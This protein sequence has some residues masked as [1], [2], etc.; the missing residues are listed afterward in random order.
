MHSMACA[1]GR[2]EHAESQAMGLC[3]HQN[4]LK[5]HHNTYTFKSAFQ[6]LPDVQIQFRDKFSLSTF[7]GDFKFH[8]FKAIQGYFSY[9]FLSVL[10]V[11]TYTYLPNTTL[12][13]IQ[14]ARVDMTLK[15][16]HTNNNTCQT[17]HSHITKGLPGTL[18]LGHY[19][20]H[21]YIY[22]GT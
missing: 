12:Q 5:F 19:M 7:R 16:Q 1:L 13:A 9:F 17:I 3:N 6:S 15:V 20:Q 21:P 10:S 18:Q 22:N 4:K 11:C 14:M 2:A 8:T